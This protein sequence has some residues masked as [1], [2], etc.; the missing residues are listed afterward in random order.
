M[1]HKRC[2]AF[3]LEIDHSLD[4][5]LKS[6]LELLKTELLLGTEPVEAS[7]LSA[8]ELLRRDQDVA[9]DLNDTIGSNTILDTDARE[10]VDLDVDEATVS[11]NINR[12]GVVL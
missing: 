9:D 6:G 3:D 11:T 2:I 1:L 7:E 5:R 8:T 10:G 12:Q 4:V